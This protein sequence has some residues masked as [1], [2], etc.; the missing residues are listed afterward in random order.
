MAEKY[1]IFDFDGTVGD[2]SEGVFSC[3][4]HAF[5]KMGMEVPDSAE[6]R[7]FI[8]PPLMESFMTRHGLNEAEASRAVA[9]YREVYSESGLLLC[10]AY[11]GIEE[12]LRRLKEQ[13]FILAVATS[14]PEIYARKILQNLGLDGYF[15]FIAGAE[16]KGKR[17]DKINVLK[18]C[19]ENLGIDPCEAIMIGDRYHDIEGAKHFNM[20]SVY[21]LWGFGNREE[22]EDYGADFICSDTEELYITLTSL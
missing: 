9:F 14:K 2:S 3:V 13:G 16:M 18:Y 15:T 5:E 1:I 4:I 6:L 11:E 7:R 22:A 21:V 20:R 17:T 10:R 12:L 19:I 8:G